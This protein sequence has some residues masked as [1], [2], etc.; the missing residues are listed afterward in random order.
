MVFKLL[1]YV[2]NF[3]RENVPYQQLKT[4]TFIF[5]VFINVNIEIILNE[6][7]ISVEFYEV[8]EKE[9]IMQSI[10]IDL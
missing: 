10:K 4:K 6:M 3:F 5:F 9:K 7:K 8:K 2:K 1:Q